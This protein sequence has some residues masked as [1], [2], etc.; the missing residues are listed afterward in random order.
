MPI[1]GEI[2]GENLI[3]LGDE[4]EVLAGNMKPRG[5]KNAGNNRCKIKRNNGYV[6]IK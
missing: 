5:R 4:E 1:L 2:Q 6:T 3:V